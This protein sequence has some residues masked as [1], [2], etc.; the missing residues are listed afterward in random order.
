MSAIW[1]I[2]ERAERLHPDRA[3]TLEGRDAADYRRFGARIRRMAAFL[4]SRGVGPGERVAILEWNTAAFLEAYFAAAGLGAILV[5]LNVRLAPPEQARVLAHCGARWLLASSG[6]ADTIGRALEESETT[7]TLRG[8]LWLDARPQEPVSRGLGLEEHAYAALRDAGEPAF[9]PAR[10]SASDV[11]HLYY[12]SGTTGRPKGAVIDQ[13][14]AHMRALKLLLELRLHPDDVL[15]FTTPMFHISCLVMS[16]MGLMRG[17]TQA[18]LPQFE[19]EATLSLLRRGQVTFM[20]TVPTMLSMIL[21]RPGFTPADFGRLR[22]IMYTAAPISLPLLR[23]LLEVYRGDL[24]QF[25]GQTEDLPQT[26][27]TPE[28]HRRALA[29]GDAR[30][31]SVGRPCMGVE[32]QILDGAGHPL[33]RGSVGEIATRGGTAMSGYWGQKEETARTLSEGW[34]HSGDLGVQD[35]DGY[36]TLAGRKKHMIIRGGENVYPAEVE[37][38]L[39]QAPGVR[40]GV[41]LGLPD[42]RWGETIVAVVAATA[43]RR[44]GDGVIAHCRRHLASYKC[45]ERVIYRD[46]LPYNAAGKILRHVLLA[47]LLSAGPAASG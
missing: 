38:I 29:G 23:R 3:A 2:L 28:D 6:F 30:L 27:L 40:D 16:L 42:E 43:D 7:A 14:C 11:A 35:A 19:L 13:K 47:E 44:D 36:V 24:V 4:R 10:V 39:M 5:P 31:G 21:D 22:T 15:H 25:L 32:L 45:P 18:V 17:A 12:T 34:V 41:I 20:N 46:A 37:A 33:P 8:I 1:Q 26:V 9:E